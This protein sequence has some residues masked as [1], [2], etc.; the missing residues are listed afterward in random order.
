MRYT[1]IAFFLLLGGCALEK[2]YG[3]P[4]PVW[5]QLTPEQKKA[6]MEYDAKKSSTKQGWIWKN[7]A[8]PQPLNPDPKKK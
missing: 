5:S 4:Q 1:L 6:I 3:I 8:E 2:P 7:S